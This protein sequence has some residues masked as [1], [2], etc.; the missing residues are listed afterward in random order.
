MKLFPAVHL[1]FGKRGIGISA[2]VPGLRVGVDSR[3]KAYTS[4]A[5][6]GTGLSVRNYA[7]RGDPRSQATQNAV[8]GWCPD[9]PRVGAAAAGRSGNLAIKRMPATTTPF[10]R[11]RY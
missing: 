10:P 8:V 6:P 9:R 7:R 11:I 1:N 3:G 4:A 2:G 5:I